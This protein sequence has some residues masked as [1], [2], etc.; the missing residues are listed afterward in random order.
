MAQSS[1]GL[2]RQAGACVLS[3]HPRQPAKTTPERL[4][5][6]NRRPF[7]ASQWSTLGRLTN[8]QCSMNPIGTYF[9]NIVLLPVAVPRATHQQQHSFPNSWQRSEHPKIAAGSVHAEPPLPQPPQSAGRARER[10][11]GARSRDRGPPRQ[12]PLFWL[13]ACRAH[14]RP[15]RRMLTIDAVGAWH[16]RTHHRHRAGLDR[17]DHRP[18]LAWTAAIRVGGLAKGDEHPCASPSSPI[19]NSILRAW[20]RPDRFVWN[21]NPRVLGFARVRHMTKQKLGPVSSDRKPSESLQTDIGRPLWSGV[22]DRSPSSARCRN[23]RTRWL[24]GHPHIVSGILA[25]S[26]RPMG[27]AQ[28]HR[29]AISP[30]VTAFATRPSRER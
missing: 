23:P 11:A 16:R 25:D 14:R 19:G 24:E 12:P 17:G 3:P 18:V 1:R 30:T 22:P 9:G 10:R 27:A 26:M 5:A 21:T 13:R 28:D 7:I 15:L 4:I 8:R 20:G 2:L 29:R 6:L